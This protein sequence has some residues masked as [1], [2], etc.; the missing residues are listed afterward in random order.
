MLT[1]RHA[2]RKAKQ[3]AVCGP[4]VFFHLEILF[5]RNIDV[6]GREVSI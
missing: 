2:D 5:I 1:R 3:P 6:Q 4:E